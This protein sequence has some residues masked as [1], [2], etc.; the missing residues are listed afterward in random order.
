MAKANDFSYEVVERI[1]VISRNGENTLELRKISYNGAE[2]KLDLR[3]WWTDDKGVEHM[4]K[5]VTL[6]E[7]ELESLT[8][9]G[10]QDYLDKKD[11]AEE[12]E[13]PKAKVTQF[14]S[15]ASA[16]KKSTTTKRTSTTK[17]ASAPK[18]SGVTEVINL[19]FK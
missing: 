9:V 17:K 1:A 18:K 5:G 15:K 10:V 11:N 16:P 6:T 13:T 7:R 14:K 19:P 2:A 4:G 12:E 8:A 3:R